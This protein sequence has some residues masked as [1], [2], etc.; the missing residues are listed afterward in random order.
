[1]T[2][3]YPEDTKTQSEDITMRFRTT[4]RAGLL[5]STNNDHFGDKLELTVTGGKLRMMIRIGDLEKVNMKN[6]LLACMQ[7]EL[8]AS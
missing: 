5:F 7:P 1:M 8:Q 6:I 4:R 3:T 2:I